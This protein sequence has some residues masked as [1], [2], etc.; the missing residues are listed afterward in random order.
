MAERKK[1]E[2]NKNNQSALERF[3]SGF[4]VTNFVISKESQRPR[5]RFNVENGTD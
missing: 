5:N 3:V 4:I 2:F 1:A